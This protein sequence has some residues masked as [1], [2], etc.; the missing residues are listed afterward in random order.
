[1]KSAKS[2]TDKLLIKIFQNGYIQW[3][4]MPTPDTLFT[5]PGYRWAEVNYDGCFFRA[6]GKGANPFNNKEQEDAIRNI[7]GWSG[8]DVCFTT[9]ELRPEK[10]GA[11]LRRWAFNLKRGG[12]SRDIAFGDLRF[13][14]SRVVPT[15]EENRPRNKTFIIWKLEKI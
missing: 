12:D 9:G 15:A 2:Y 7:K 11:F 4:G 6:K 10:T 1:M 13:D 8:S 3:P 14:A 5:F